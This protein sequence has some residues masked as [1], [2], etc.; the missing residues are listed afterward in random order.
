MLAMFLCLG[1]IIL[2]AGSYYAY[3]IAFYSPPKDREKVNNPMD[4]QYDPYRPEMK[5]IYHQL[6]NRPYERVS[7]LSEDGLKLDGRYYHVKDGAT[8]DIGFHGYRSNPITDFPAVPSFP[9]RWSITS[10]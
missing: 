3:R 5:R 8:L 7:I 9:F 6:N 10:C 2:L 1:A 4:P